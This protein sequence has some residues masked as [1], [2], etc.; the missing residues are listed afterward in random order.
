MELVDERIPKLREL[1]PV[2]PDETFPPSECLVFQDRLFYNVLCEYISDWCKGSGLPSEVIGG[3]E[4]TLG[5]L[6]PFFVDWVGL[7]CTLLQCL[8]G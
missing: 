2:F 7:V 8:V 1:L 5:E 3:F 4:G 6:Q